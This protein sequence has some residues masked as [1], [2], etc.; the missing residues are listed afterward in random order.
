MSAAA[1]CLV[2]ELNRQYVCFQAHFC[3]RFACLKEHVRVK[4]LF[5][6]YLVSAWACFCPEL[7]ASSLLMF[8][9]VLSMEGLTHCLWY[10]VVHRYRKA[11]R[12][13]VPSCSSLSL[14]KQHVCVLQC[15][16]WDWWFGS[17]YL[18]QDFLWV[19]DCIYLVLHLSCK[20]CGCAAAKPRSHFNPINHDVSHCVY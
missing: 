11:E 14:T 8:Y 18:L 6:L 12:D 9:W 20:C 16:G 5:R 17:N 1:L 3:C 15:F 2:N 13:F 4:G 7:W 10:G 19:C